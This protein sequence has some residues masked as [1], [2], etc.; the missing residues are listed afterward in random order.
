MSYD[1]ATNRR[2]LSFHFP[3]FDFGT[4][5]D[6][7]RVIQLPTVPERDSGQTQKFNGAR[8][9]GALVSNVTEDFAG[10]TTDSGIQVGDGTD[11]D[12]YYDSGL[13]LDETVDIGESVF[14]ADDGA[15]VDVPSGASTVGSVTVTFVA[16]TGSPTGIA[17]VTLF[18]DLF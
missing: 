12:K 13:V 3:S 11:A 5:S 9:F 4:G 6:V 1:G 8:V 18:V 7:T 16:A 2:T 10:V 17:D 15:A 14:L